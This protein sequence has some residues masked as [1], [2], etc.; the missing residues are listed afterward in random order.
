MSLY[1]GQLMIFLLIA[2]YLDVV[3][4]LKHGG[5]PPFFFNCHMQFLS[6]DHVYR[7]Q[8][9]KFMR[10]VEKDVSFERLS[11]KEIFS[12]VCALLDIT[13][14]TQCSEQT[15]Q[16]FGQTHNWVK[17]KAFFWSCLIGILC[18]FAII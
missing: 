10:R 4:H 8:R 7:K 9:D 15:I 2:C 11:G 1:C 13:F 14:D 12:Q 5:K 16:S 18:L 17:K 3:F 6:L